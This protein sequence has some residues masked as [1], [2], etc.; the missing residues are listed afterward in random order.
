MSITEAKKLIGCI[1]SVSW[2]DRKGQELTEESRVY[3]VTFVPLY[4]G[5]MIMERDDVRLDRVTSI[6][7]V[8]ED[9]TR[10]LAY[11]SELARVP[12]AA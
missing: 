11:E 1:C 5:Y 2:L 3:D 6:F 12:K 10:H 9:G 4:G 7:L 8:Q